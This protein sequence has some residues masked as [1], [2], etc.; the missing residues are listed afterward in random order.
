MINM[1]QIFINLPVD[2]LEKSKNFYTEIGFTVNPL[3]TFYDQICMV[4]SEHI[5]VMLQTKYFFYSGNKTQVLNLNNNSSSTF[6]LP[7][8]GTKEVNEIV[9]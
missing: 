1:K 2:D 9:E 7:V 4:W 6:T 3:F 8:G 5:Y